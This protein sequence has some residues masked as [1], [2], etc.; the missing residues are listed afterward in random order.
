MGC[1]PALEKLWDSA[2]HAEGMGYERGQDMV[3]VHKEL[4]PWRRDS[5]M[6]AKRANKQAAGK[7]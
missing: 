3:P 7:I 4:G 6:L 1:P 5:G 2:W